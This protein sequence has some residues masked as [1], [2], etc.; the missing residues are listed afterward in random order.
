MVESDVNTMRMQL[1]IYLAE[2]F[3]LSDYTKYNLRN[4]Y[5]KFVVPQMYRLPLILFSMSAYHI[6]KARALQK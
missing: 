4:T 2:M 6:M 1:F 5:L 3:S